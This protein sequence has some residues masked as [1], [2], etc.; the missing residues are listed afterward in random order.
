MKPQ[1]PER[2]TDLPPVTNN[3]NHKE[4]IEYTSRW[5][6]IEL[7]SLVVT[8]LIVHICNSSYHVIV[9]MTILCLQEEFED[10]NRG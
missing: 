4:F 3:I 8:P 10:K 5:K 2:K 6:V 9:V 1:Y 7:T